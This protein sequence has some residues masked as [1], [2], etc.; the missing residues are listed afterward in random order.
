MPIEFEEEQSL[1]QRIKYEIREH[2]L[3]RSIV[4]KGSRKVS[5][6]GRFGAWRTALVKGT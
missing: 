3:R 1:R 5:V 2:Y 6:V 4:G